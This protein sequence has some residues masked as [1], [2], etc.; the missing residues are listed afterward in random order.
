MRRPDGTNRPRLLS[1]LTGSA[2]AKVAGPSR[3]QSK[4]SVHTGTTSNYSTGSRSS[5]RSFMRDLA[6]DMFDKRSNRAAM[7]CSH[8][9]PP[10]AVQKQGRPT[11]GAAP[12]SNST[13]GRL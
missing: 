1:S 13:L 6:S 12:I 5:N 9:G 10:A 3:D 11:R 7:A 8:M 2:G 4:L